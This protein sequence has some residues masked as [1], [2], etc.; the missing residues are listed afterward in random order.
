MKTYRRA[1]SR[2]FFLDYGGTLVEKEGFERD[3]KDDFL[4]VLRR[5][6]RQNML[7]A[8]NLLASDPRNHIWIMSSS[9]QRIMI[10]SLEGISNIGMISNS[11]MFYRHVC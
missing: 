8:L 10:Q 9:E 4:G 5:K 3:L 1:K 11:G 7:N 2:L 6:P